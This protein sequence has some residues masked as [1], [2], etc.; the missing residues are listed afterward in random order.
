MRALVL[1]IAARAA[2]WTV[3]DYAAAHPVSRTQLD[4]MENP[5]HAVSFDL[6]HVVMVPVGFRCVYSVED[7][8]I[9]RCRHLSVSIDV[10]GST[11]HPLA[12]VTLME[13]FGFSAASVEL[14]QGLAVGQPAMPVRPPT[15]RMWMESGPPLAIN[16]VEAISL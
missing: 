9:G 13:A 12:V 14:L 10:D 8:P 7:Q 3:R 15:A 2:I 5:S 11:P 1:D 6:N 16:V 4:T